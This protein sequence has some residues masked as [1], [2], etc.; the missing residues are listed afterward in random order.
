[1]GTGGNGR[2]KLMNVLDHYVPVR[3]LLTWGFVGVSMVIGGA[4]IE[5]LMVQ[6]YD[7]MANQMTIQSAQLTAQEV[8]LRQIQDTFA[9][10]RASRDAQLNQIDGRIDGITAKQE[11]AA[12]Q[13]GA[14]HL[15]MGNIVNDMA[16]L[17]CQVS[18]RC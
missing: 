18:H 13:I 4:K 15:Q 17:K 12:E 10:A 2:S 3:N 1:M 14:L 5:A 11:V 8:Q 6:Q 16:V 9:T 7:A